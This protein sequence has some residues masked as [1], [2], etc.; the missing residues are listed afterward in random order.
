M[1]ADHIFGLPSV[2]LHTA[3]RYGLETQ[4]LLPLE[5]YGPSGLYE[6]LCTSLRLSESHTYRKI[7]VHEMVISETDADCISDSNGKCPWR[8]S[9][10]YYQKNDAIS[11]YLSAH[12]HSEFD[13]ITRRELHSTDG[14]WTLVDNERVSR[15]D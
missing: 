11:A 14:L 4:K 10:S 5:I 7:V 3:T 6:Y 13:N 12:N 15:I 1:H 2:V 9:V 8:R